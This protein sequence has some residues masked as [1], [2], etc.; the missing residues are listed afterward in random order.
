MSH[1]EAAREA[2]GEHEL[3]NPDEVAEQPVGNLARRENGQRNNYSEKDDLQRDEQAPDKD[4]PPLLRD[5]QEAAEWQDLQERKWLQEQ[6][7][8][9]S[10]D[11]GHHVKAHRLSTSFLMASNCRSASS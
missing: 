9:R 2:E 5:G 11:E 6:D 4:K 8:D 1:P 10:D 3:G 7:V